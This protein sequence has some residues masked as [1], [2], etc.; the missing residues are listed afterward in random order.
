MVEDAQ[1]VVLTGMP[2][3]TAFMPCQRESSST[4]TSRLLPY[5]PSTVYCPSRQL[6]AKQMKQVLFDGGQPG[7]S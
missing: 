2:D 3:I 5:I 6:E 1:A 4:M 7:Q